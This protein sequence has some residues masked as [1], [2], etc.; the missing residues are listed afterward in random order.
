MLVAIARNG[1]ADQWLQPTES[2]F[3][4]ADGRIAVRLTPGTSWGEVWGFAGAPLGEHARAQFFRLAGDERAYSL[5]QE[6]EL[7]NPIAPVFAAVSN[8]GALITLDNW[9]NMGFGPILVI[10]SPAGAIV[11]SY[12]LEDLYG[13]EQIDKFV[14]SVSSRWWRCDEDPQ[15]DSRGSNLIIVDQLANRLEVDLTTGGVTFSRSETGC[16]E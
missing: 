9:H 15:L 14:A 13:P 16:A 6:L 11:R 12:T 5:Y 2:G 10:Y 7:L 3:I 8:E 1:Y 4:S